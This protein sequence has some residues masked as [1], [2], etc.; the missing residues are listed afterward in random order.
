MDELDPLAIGEAEG[1]LDT[2]SESFIRVFG[3]NFLAF[4]IGLALAYFLKWELADL[5]WTL[6]L[7][8]LVV[9]YVTILTRIA[10]A[11]YFGLRMMK[12]PEFD[13]SH[14]MGMIAGGVGFGLFYLGFFSLHF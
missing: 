4:G 12:H 2:S 8:R 13:P 9:G 14:R 11:A 6:W 5:V 7:S 1:R 3:P 10:G